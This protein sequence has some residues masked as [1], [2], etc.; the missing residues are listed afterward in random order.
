MLGKSIRTGRTNTLIGE[1]SSLLG[2]AVLRHRTRM[3]E[4]SARIESE[5]ANRVK[6]EFISNMS[7]EL[8]TPLNTIIGF[9]KILSEQ[10]KRQIPATDIIEYAQLI[11]DSAG[12]LLS[13]IND[14]LDI[15]KIQS[16]KFT[17]DARETNVDDILAYCIASFR[18]LA[19][20]A[21]V[22]IA[23]TIQEPIPP[24]RGDPAKLKQ[25]FSNILSNAIKFTPT[26]GRVIISALATVDGG[27][28]VEFKDTGVGMSEDELEIAMTPFGQVD[29]SKTRWR[30]GTGLGLPIA[31]SLVD[32][33]G[34]R[35]DIKSTKGKGTTV[36]VMLPSRHL[37]SAARGREMVLGQQI[38]DDN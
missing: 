37:V 28:V 30:E 34:G 6:S 8:R 18:K 21:G 29:G 33:H 11:H 32:L 10:D 23:N 2:D 1:Y 24:I 13:V 5:L 26:G 31:H 7:H 14:I 36:S 38:G 27:L 20:D 22:E 4:H 25:I 12:H 16:G 17:I 19:E 3:A 9:S 35:L 15:S